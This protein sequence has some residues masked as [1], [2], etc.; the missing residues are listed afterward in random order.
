MMDFLGT[1]KWYLLKLE[2]YPLKRYSLNGSCCLSNSFA[3]YF[4]PPICPDLS[5]TSFSFLLYCTRTRSPFTRFRT[6]FFSRWTVCFWTV[7]QF[8]FLLVFEQFCSWVSLICP[9]YISFSSSL[10]RTRSSFTLHRTRLSS[11]WTLSRSKFSQ[12]LLSDP[13]I[14]CFAGEGWNVNINSSFR[15]HDLSIT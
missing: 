12:I 11:R 7:E 15:R 4:S 14:D 5:H 13:V 8:V 1:S 10:D 3:L 9:V 6:W 2:K